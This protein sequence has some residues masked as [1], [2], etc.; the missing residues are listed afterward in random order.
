MSTAKNLAELPIWQGTPEIKPLA[1]GRTNQNYLVWD[2]DRRFFA[3]IGSDRQDLGID[4][5]SEAICCQLA[6]THGIGPAVIY[7]GDAILVQDYLPG[8]TLH[9][10]ETPDRNVLQ[11]LATLLGRLH[12]VPV[13]ANLPAFDP[14]AV[15]R[16]YLADLTDL[17]LPEER[18]RVANTLDR[19]RPGRGRSVVHGDLIPENILCDGGRLYLIDWEY[20]GS[21]APETDLA[22][23]LANF[24]L[25]EGDAAHF[26]EAYGDYDTGVLYDMKIACVIREAL[27]CLLQARQNRLKGEKSGDL[28]AYTALCFQRL[29]DVLT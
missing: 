6:A 25:G 14:V 8:E 10:E 16:R 29:R 12:Q 17:E 22:L 15:S 2:G 20:A 24:G 5:V 1:A 4:R 27:W 23:V 28:P 3:R 26:L 13:P 7:A 11:E 21:G 18:H 9:L 19:L